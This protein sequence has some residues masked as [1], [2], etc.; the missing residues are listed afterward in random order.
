MLCLSGLYNGA[1]RQKLH[2][3]P[4]TGR[5]DGDRPWERENVAG[6]PTEA[7]GN[8]KPLATIYADKE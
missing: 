4:I 6:F 3:L 1:E 8:D 5:A 7:F 2:S